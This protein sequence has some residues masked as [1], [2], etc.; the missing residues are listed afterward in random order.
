MSVRFTGICRSRAALRAFTLIELLVVIV[1][2]ALLISLLLPGLNRAKEAARSAKCMANESEFGRFAHYKA[3]EDKYERLQIPHPVSGDDPLTHV[4]AP[5][6]FGPMSVGD[7]DWGGA[8]GQDAV[9]KFRNT[10]QF[11]GDRGANGRY[12]NKMYMAKFVTG[13]QADQKNKDYRLFLCPSDKGI[14]KDVHS[15]GLRD[16]TWF[17]AQYGWD[18]SVFKAAGNS[19]QGDFFFVKTH[20]T[21][22]PGREY[23]R[24]GAYNRP[25]RKFQTPNQNILYWETRFIQA[26]ANTYEMGTSSPSNGMGAQP[27]DVPSWHSPQPKFNVVFVDGHVSKITLRSRGD[28]NRPSDYQ[29]AQNP[30][31]WK[32]YWRGKNWRYDAFPFA[33]QSRGWTGDYTVPRRLEV[34]MPSGDG[35]DFVLTPN[36]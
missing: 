24:W 16:A 29:S 25:L 1:I 4:G 15:V 5:T 28:M 31:Y 2:I 10:N 21:G 26:L 12:M 35:G 14:Y 30:Y 7:H 8:D 18:Q 3:Q 36:Y 17:T 9:L 20:S 34:T 27:K 13:S 22:V 32:L 19:Y 23:R 11:I 6:T 33:N